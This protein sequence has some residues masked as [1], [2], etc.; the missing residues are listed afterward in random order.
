[1]RK[2]VAR[3]VAV[4]FMLLVLLQAVAVFAQGQQEG[5]KNLKVLPKDISRRELTAIMNKFEDATGL[6]C[7]DC[8]AQSK[9]SPGR[10]DFA[11][12]D[13]PEKETARKMM[14]M[15]ASINEQVGAMGL[16]D[17]AKVE[18]M[19]C[20]HGVAEPVTLASKLLKA[21]DKGGV[22]AAIAAYRDLR[23]EYYGSAAYDFS[24]HG[25]N[26]AA[27]Q[28]AETKQD[29]DGAMAL[30]KLNLEFYPN[31]IGTYVR[32]S[33]VQMAKGDKPGAIASMEKAVSLDPA[34]N[35]LKAQLDR[36]KNGQ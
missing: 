11:S 7:G 32:M 27:G 16:K 13:K 25:L 23:K 3:L 26:D 30:F 36:L 2:S 5:P 19:T 22:N 1:M 21:S 15:V 17:A 20:H 8:H 24:A 33:R 35:R 29:F 9:T 28:F 10:L 18:C 6:D 4:P 31:D 12:D 34:N 14:K